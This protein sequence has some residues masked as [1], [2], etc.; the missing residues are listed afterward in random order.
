[1]W[2][3]IKIIPEGSI[4]EIPIDSQS[5]SEN[6]DPRSQQASQCYSYPNSHI[7]QRNQNPSNKTNESNLINQKPRPQRV[8][9][10]QRMFL[11]KSEKNFKATELTIPNGVINYFLVKKLGRYTVNQKRA[12]QLQRTFSW[13]IRRNPSQSFLFSLTFV[14]CVVGMS[15]SDSSFFRSKTIW[16]EWK[17]SLASCVRSYRCFEA[18]FGC[19]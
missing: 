12:M 3:W 19:L 6:P 9:T 7:N 13:R 5:F 16:A 2:H 10:H 17:S 4:S 1:M 8:S 18:G 15:R 11:Q 14:P